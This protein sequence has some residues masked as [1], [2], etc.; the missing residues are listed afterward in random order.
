MYLSTHHINLSS[1]GL[2]GVLF[3]HYP[4][5][6][7]YFRPPQALPPVRAGCH[8]K[9]SPKSRW[10]A[11]NKNATKPIETSLKYRP[12]FFQTFCDYSVLFSFL[13]VERG[14]RLRQDRCSKIFRLTIFVLSDPKSWLFQHVVVVRKTAKNFTEESVVKPAKFFWAMKPLLFDVLDTVAVDVS[15]GPYVND[16]RTIT[17][18]PAQFSRGVR[19]LVHA[20]EAKGPF[21]SDWTIIVLFY[22]FQRM[23]FSRPPLVLFQK[24]L[25]RLVSLGA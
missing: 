11:I 7:W 15:Q 25:V 6:R 13:K 5:H 12:R 14:M 8:G 4:L 23:P 1:A 9:P 18:S 10:A 19:I 20:P 3:H 17:H 21:E 22:L 24:Y 16:I 2:C